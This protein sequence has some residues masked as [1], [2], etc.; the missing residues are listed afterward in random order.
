MT[1]ILLFIA[2]A[3]ALIGGIAY[4]VFTYAPII[5]NF[6]NSMYEFYTS[7]VEYFPDWL[8]PFLA[9]PILI[10]LVGLLIKLL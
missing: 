6:W 2:S 4:F 3:V 8:V 9:I 1:S 7:V 10:G 5:A